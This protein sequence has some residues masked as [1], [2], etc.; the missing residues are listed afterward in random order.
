MAHT[1]ACDDQTRVP[2]TSPVCGGCRRRLRERQR[3][4]A[5]FPEGIPLPIW[6][7]QHDHTTPYPGDRGLHFEPMTPEDA[8]ALRAWAEERVKTARRR[9]LALVGP[10]EERERSDPVGTAAD[11]PTSLS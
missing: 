3:A 10:S 9:R 8:A 11:K 2:I 4:C 5:A 7:G 1:E 6:L